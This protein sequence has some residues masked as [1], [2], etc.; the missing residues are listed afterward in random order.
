MPRLI[1]HQQAPVWPISSPSGPY[2]RLTRGT[3][4]STKHQAFGQKL[5]FSSTR[6]KTHRDVCLSL[7][8]PGMHRTSAFPGECTWGYPI[9]RIQH[10]IRSA[11]Y[12]PIGLSTTGLHL[13]SSREP[14]IRLSRVILGRN[15]RL[16]HQTTKKVVWVWASRNP[17]RL[18]G[19]LSLLVSS[20]SLGG[21]VH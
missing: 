1:S 9:R 3:A 14:Q 4:Y 15:A 12:H 8:Y 10:Y 6:N 18:L 7:G 11:S 19:I 2:K 16:T 13:S 5:H 17:I 21:S 20:G